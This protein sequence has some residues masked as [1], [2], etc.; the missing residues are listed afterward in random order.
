[1]R[2]DVK[3]LIRKTVLLEGVDVPDWDSVLDNNPLLNT[4]IALLKEIEKLGGDAYVVGGAARDI[5]MGSKIKDV[6][7]ATNVPMDKIQKTFKWNAIGQSQDFGIIMVHFQGEEFEVAGF[8]SE[9]GSA[10][11]RRPDSV[12]MIQSFETDS[13]R[14]D[15][16]I[17]SMGINSDGKLV[18]YQ[19]G[20]DDIKKKVIRAVGVA[21]NRFQEDALRILRAIRFAV[22]YGF[23]IESE[24]KKA[25]IELKDLIEK[26]SAERISEELLK[27]ASNGKQLSSYV[28]HLDDV[29]ILQ[30]ILPE[31]KALQGKEQNP[32]HHPEGSAYI[33]SLRAVENT[34]SNDPVVNIAILFHDLGKGVVQS[35][36]KDGYPTYYGHHNDSGIIVDEIGKRLK[37][38]SKMKTA[39]KF[40]AINH[41]KAHNFDTLSNK[42]VYGLVSDPNWYVLKEVIYADIMARGNVDPSE[43]L[44][45]IEYAE[46]LVDKMN[47]ASSG[48]SLENAIKEKINGH[49]VM[50]LTGLGSG[51]Q[52]GK[53]ISTVRD[54]IFDVG[55]ENASEQAI[56]D[57]VLE[58]HNQLKRAPEGAPSSD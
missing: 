37:W 2:I 22:R 46:A 27:V 48:D 42:K 17:N 28:Q 18:D 54:W 13:K 58:V 32:K 34:R 26:L 23:E 57:K 15:I 40:A 35:E 16:T 19:G 33:H 31:L 41:M 10:D 8:R 51:A 5:M 7:I 50:K 55:I 39:V 11:S 1:M 3:N 24:T 14:R 12:E 43:P 9:E 38:S 49:L 29:G 52:L 21:S 4:G 44:K 6:D 30:L 20:L 45:N 53:I 25:M 47:S 56:K 36:P